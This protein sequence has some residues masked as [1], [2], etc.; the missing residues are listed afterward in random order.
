VG[1][2]LWTQSEV[3]EQIGIYTATDGYDEALIVSET[4]RTLSQFP[5][6]RVAVLYRTNFQ[7]RLLEQAFTRAGIKYTVLGGVG[8]WQRAEIMDI[9]AYLKLA[10]SPSDSVSFRRVVNWPRRGIGNAT[11]KQIED[12]ARERNTNLWTAMCDLIRDGSFAAR[13]L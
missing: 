6:D 11:L 8:F 4:A 2:S 9:I 5:L 1:K 3:G 10:L 13:T 7:S 12:A